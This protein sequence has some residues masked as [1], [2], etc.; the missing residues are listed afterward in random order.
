MAGL[1]Y[2]VLT[3]PLAWL[4]MYIAE[5]L[6][7]PALY[8]LVVGLLIAG[9]I[10]SAVFYAWLHAVLNPRRRIQTGTGG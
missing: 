5:S 1:R 8:G 9:A 6:E 7:K 3:A 4:G 2:G 10:S